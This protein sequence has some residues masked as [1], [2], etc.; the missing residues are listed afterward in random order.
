MK[1][2]RFS[3]FSSLQSD[4]GFCVGRSLESLPS[5][6]NDCG[7]GGGFLRIDFPGVGI[8]TA[9]DEGDGEEDISASSRAKVPSGK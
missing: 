8:V 6:K 4:A 7:G 1:C 3:V 2:A 5:E 9:D